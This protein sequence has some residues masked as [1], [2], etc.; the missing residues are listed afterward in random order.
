LAQVPLADAADASGLLTTAVRLGQVVGVAVFG[1]LFLA[2]ASHAGPARGLLPAAPHAV[3]VTSTWLAM[4][5]V[6]GALA[7]LPL[8][9]RR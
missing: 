9:R 1:S 8:A 3:E 5:F 6:A 2:L 7:A 4:V